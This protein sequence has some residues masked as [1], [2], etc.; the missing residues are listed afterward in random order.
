MACPNG[1]R[2]C[3]GPTGFGNKCTH[4]SK[5][6]TTGSGKTAAPL[7]KVNVPHAYAVLPKPKVSV[8]TPEAILPISL[9]KVPTADTIVPVA[10]TGRAAKVLLFRG[11]TREPGVIKRDGFELWGEAIANV[12]KAKGIG[13]YLREACRKYRN[14]RTLADWVRA[15]KDQGR[16]TVSTSKNEGC[17][18]Y[19]SGYIYKMQYDDLQEFEFDERILPPGAPLNWNSD[20]L[21]LYMDASNVQHA[22]TIVI[23]LKLGTEEWAF[24]TK[25]AP[26]RIVEYKA[27]GQAAFQPMSAVAVTSRKLW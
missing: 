27:S 1:V 18:G 22:K 25:V 3:P 5:P 24:F 16:P 6:Q 7:P 9:V 2:W 19:S 23:D 13:N 15:M 4:C 14:G 12:S 17:G 20:G 21:K 10:A 26:A 8:P 11:D